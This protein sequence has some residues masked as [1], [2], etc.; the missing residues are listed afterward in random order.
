MRDNFIRTG[1]IVRSTQTIANKIIAR[2]TQS[3]Q[4]Q[5]ECRT[6]H[7]LLININ[8]YLQHTQAHD[9]NTH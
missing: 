9:T 3:Y 6:S 8:I 2:T 1:I 7:Q 4:Y 5:Q